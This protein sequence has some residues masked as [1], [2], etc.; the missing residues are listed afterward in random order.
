MLN[1]SH[2]H[3]LS[4]IVYVVDQFD[5]GDYV[6]ENNAIEALTG[7]IRRV[8][9]RVP[10]DLSIR[11][12]DSVGMR[13]SGSSVDGNTVDIHIPF[14]PWEDILL[15]DI[16]NKIE[17]ALNSNQA[18]ELPL[19]IICVKR[20][21]V[22][23]LDRLEGKGVPFQGNFS[24][25]ASKKKS[26]VQINPEQDQVNNKTN[27][28]AQ[29]IVIGLAHLISQGKMKPIEELGLG[30]DSY[31][32]LVTSASKFKNRKE[33]SM[34]LMQLL[35]FS[36]VNEQV[37]ERVE[38]RFNVHLVLFSIRSMICEFPPQN[39]LPYSDWKEVIC[40]LL[41]G[42]KQG[43][44]DWTHVDYISKPTAFHPETNHKSFR[45]CYHCV[46]PYKRK[47]GCDVKECKEDGTPRCS[48]C[49]SCG[50]NACVACDT[51]DCGYSVS[52]VEEE[53]LPFVTKTKCPD[54]FCLLFSPKCK[55]LHALSCKVVHCKRCS[56]CG[57][58]AHPGLK[59]YEQR[60][61][62]CSDKFPK[63]ELDQ[64]R[65]YLKREKLKENKTVLASYDFECCIGENN[66]HVPY[67]C[68][69][70]FPEV[71]PQEELLALHYPFEKRTDGTRVFV[72]WGLGDKE[73][74]TG[75]Y[76]FFHFC[77]DPL[78][79]GT[80]FWAHNAR[81][82]DAILVKCYFAKFM[83]Q[84]SIDIQR[85]QKLM[86]MR[87]TELE[88]DFRD[89]LSFIPSSLR[90]MSEDFGITV[91][92]EVN[93]QVEAGGKDFFPHSYVTEA[94]LKEAAVSNFIT[95]K[96]PAEEF[97]PDYRAGRAGESEEKEYLQW[98]EQ[99]YSQWGDTWNVK[100]EAVKYCIKDT[101]LLGK[102]LVKFRD[103]LAQMTA[104]IPRSADVELQE[105][106]ALAYIT[107]P[108]AMMSFYLSQMLEENTIGVIQSST[109]LMRREA[110]TWF[111]WLEFKKDA[112]L[113][114]RPVPEIYSQDFDEGCQTNSENGE[115]LFI[116]LDCYDNGCTRCYSSHQRNIVK[117][118]SF[119]ELWHLTRANLLKLKTTFG[120]KNVHSI[121]THDWQKEKENEDFKQWFKWAR[122]EDE[123]PLIPRDA[124]K[125]GK[126]ECFKIC[127]P[128]A[129]QMS[130]FVS[131]YPTSLLGKSY[132]PLDVHGDPQ[133]TLEW[134]FPTGQPVRRFRPV[135][136]DQEGDIVMNDDY[137]KN[138]VSLGVI[139][140]RVLCPTDLYAPFLGYKVESR[141]CSNAYEVIY[142]NCRVCM[143]ER[144]FPCTHDEAVERSFVGTWT[145][146][147]VRYAV[148][149]L[150]YQILE[151]IEIWEYENRST[152]LFRSFIAPFM[153]EKIRSK[154][155][156]LVDEQG[157]FTEKGNRVNDYVEE[158]VGRRLLPE[159]IE[160]NPARR[161]VAKL[162]QNSFTGKWG[163]IEV[164]RSTR[165][166]NEKQVDESRKLLTDPG[167][168][169]LFAQVLDKEGDLVVIEY[170]PKFQCSR[171][172]RRKND[173]IVAHITAYGRMMLSRLEQALGHD[174]L[175]EDTDSAFHA[176]MET[177]CYR[178][179][180]RTGDLELELKYGSH[181]SCC[182]RKW[183]A[184]L[185]N[186][187]DP[188]SK[189]KGFTLRRS[190]VDL[191]SPQNLFRL[192]VECK[193]AFDQSEPTSAKDFNSSSVAPSIQ[194]E[195]RLFKTVRQSAVE[196]Y[197]ETQVSIKKA[198]FQICSQK[199]H[200]LFP[201]TLNKDLPVF[202]DTVPFGYK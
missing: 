170:Q 200:I 52:F 166:F 8:L 98:V 124:Y 13:I 174:I 161:Q 182:G 71:H 46:R 80:T 68:T 89:S 188:I 95:L 121:W 115:E 84:Y 47:N 187:Q 6:D 129:I 107:L 83:R 194:V 14:Q 192:F 51:T 53:C 11:A 177:P 172:A 87:Y 26:I 148:T 102:V 90:S 111:L 82:Y 109:A 93:G 77:A 15:M 173:V 1:E 28:F 168:E 130:D 134:P 147:E 123:L 76:Q 64:H 185:K 67:L 55:E 158:L 199:R 75:V 152:D 131:Q 190:N 65:C 127:Y 62:F 85:G 31:K 122:I 143:E 72:F 12:G 141:L 137:V 2:Q 191:F 140:C 48:F 178:D 60:C 32:K 155:S 125:G 25:F 18:I 92:T 196:L 41:T 88:I 162:A 114:P 150:N 57:N 179:G 66:V 40:G 79:R 59:C 73:Q 193:E 44:G 163:E 149:E 171:A 156:G 167:V 128:G 184:Y 201:E 39:R 165:T 49:H 22:A 37:L 78:L 146:S 159:E 195:Q 197:K 3:G 169:V 69:V 54:C 4:S 154:R 7:P 10:G 136:Q 103:Q 132:D 70:W 160:D 112:K 91:E 113:K 101:V 104:S 30:A 118:R 157:N 61:F 19:D 202:V 198:Q 38:S 105:F 151:V 74:G 100:T 33:A 50:T 153:V 45:F 35:C 164:H 86:S 5:E 24:V 21:R 108:S 183:Y 9:D 81:A 42:N 29:W 189:I 110:E 116:Y 16:L 106:D 17:N 99:N 181:W 180:F 96:P 94:Y 175:Y 126:V 23:R 97:I 186:G 58:K 20:H 27:C 36:T 142:G 56:E 117:N 139:K 144:Q 34:K 138:V 145:L 133:A 63:A 43:G 119:G 135:F 120:V 176:K